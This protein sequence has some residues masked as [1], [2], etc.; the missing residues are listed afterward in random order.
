MPVVTV[1]AEGC[2]FIVDPASGH[3]GAFEDVQIAVS[4]HSSMWG[5]YM[6]DLVVEVKKMY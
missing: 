2:G 1:P 5:A 3:L 6:D 4:V